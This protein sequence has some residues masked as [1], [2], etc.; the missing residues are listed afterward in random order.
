MTFVGCL[1]MLA[2]N[3]QPRARR[4]RW[5]EQKALETAPGSA[6]AVVHVEPSAHA[7]HVASLSYAL[8]VPHLAS[9]LEVRGPSRRRWVVRGRGQWRALCQG[10]VRGGSA[11]S[12]AE[13]SYIGEL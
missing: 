9:A 4:P 3:A 10:I 12:F 1:Q 8:S 13:A 6:G 5:P 7:R 11:H 2:S